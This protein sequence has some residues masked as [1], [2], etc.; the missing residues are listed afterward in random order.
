MAWKGTWP[1]TARPLRVETAALRGKPVAFAE[2]CI[3]PLAED[4][5]KVKVFSL[6]TLAVA[7][8]A[9]SRSNGARSNT[10]VSSS[11]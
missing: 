4:A 9:A 10:V 1:G 7:P 8:A 3:G 2:D 5:A 6:S 11:M